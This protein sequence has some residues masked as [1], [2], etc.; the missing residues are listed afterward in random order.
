M[1]DYKA[2]SLKPYFKSDPI[3][4]ENKEPV[5]VIV[6]DMFDDFVLNG[7]KFVLVEGYAPWCGHCKSLEPIYKELAEYYLPLSDKLVIGKMDG[8]TNEHAKFPVKGFPTIRL[9]K[10]GQ[11]NYVE[12]EG[13]RTL[14]DFISFIKKE[15]GLEITKGTPKKEQDDVSTQEEL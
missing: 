11:S 12:Y 5:K 10:P 15:T 1:K 2:K 8:T 14:N 3:P 6:A 13:G 4:K 7:G 9:F